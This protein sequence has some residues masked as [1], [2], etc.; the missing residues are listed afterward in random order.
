MMIQPSLTFN[1]IRIKERSMWIDLSKIGCIVKQIVR[2]TGPIGTVV[3]V[4]DG[5]IQKNKKQFAKE[6]AKVH[7][8]GLSDK[9]IHDKN[10]DRLLGCGFK[11]LGMV[12]IGGCLHT[13]L[14]S[15]VVKFNASTVF[16]WFYP[17]PK[18]YIAQYNPID[19]IR[20]FTLESQILSDADIARIENSIA[21]ATKKAVEKKERH[22]RLVAEQQRLKLERKQKRADAAAAAAMDK[23]RYQSKAIKPNLKSFIFG[24]ITGVSIFCDRGYDCARINLKDVTIGE[25]S[26]RQ[27]FALVVPF[28]KRKREVLFS[29]FSKVSLFYNRSL[30]ALLKRLN[31]AASLSGGVDIGLHLRQN[32]YMLDK[33]SAFVHCAFKSSLKNEPALELSDIDEASLLAADGKVPDHHIPEFFKLSFG[34]VKS[35]RSKLKADGVHGQLVGKD[36]PLEKSDQDDIIEDDMHEPGDVNGNL[37][38]NVADSQNTKKSLKEKGFEPSCKKSSQQPKTKTQKLPSILIK[39]KKKLACETSLPTC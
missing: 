5:S 19:T 31:R 9:Q 8:A 25:N 20:D 11:K 23:A 17:V 12:E 39:P 26:I 36:S 37:I 15:D 33:D 4:G 34:L 21:E 22:A 30:F 28:S 7:F 29:G 38:A 27:N 6:F 10:V 18:D 2:D 13:A 32:I 3:F 35:V 14:V 24:K 1:Q 16:E